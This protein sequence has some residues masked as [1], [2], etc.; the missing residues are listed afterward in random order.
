MQKWKT[1]L[2]IDTTKKYS[3]SVEAGSNIEVI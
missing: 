2:N 1:P 3:T